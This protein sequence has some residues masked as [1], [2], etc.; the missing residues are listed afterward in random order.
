MV[1][2]RKEKRI[3]DKDYYEVVEEVF[4]TP[5]LLA[6]YHVIRKGYID[7]MFGVVSAGKEARVYWAKNRRG[8]DVAVKIYLTTTAEFRKSIRQYI[9][10]D[11]RFE[12]VSGDLRKL[13][14]KWVRKEYKNLK[15]MY[16]A[17][18]RVPKPYYAY[19]NIL[20]MEF[21]GENGIRAPLLKE[22]RLTDEEYVEIYEKI[23]HY[24][25]LMYNKAKLVHADLSEYNIM[26]YGGEPVIIDVSQAVTLDHPM[27]MYF[28]IRDIK[29]IIRYFRDEVGIETHNLNELL[30]EITGKRL[31]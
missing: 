15:R 31:E 19:R 29:N 16:E 18:V 6:L 7:K 11:P 23:V 14:L 5:T 2:R 30:E 26:L 12:S 8:E 4:D 25:K 3:K 1:K 22:V 28:L 13:I 24:I 9:I 10:G 17:G 20:V 21:I 27:A